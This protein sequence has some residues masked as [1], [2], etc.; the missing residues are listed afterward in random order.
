MTSVARVKPGSAVRESRCL[1]AVADR[2][3]AVAAV[4][5]KSPKGWEAVVGAKVFDEQRGL[6]QA[7]PDDR[8]RVWG[9]NTFARL[10]AI[11]GKVS[12]AAAEQSGYRIPSP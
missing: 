7:Q 6:A 9:V 8:G 12:D 10:P 11:G 3:E 4:R 1:E 5:E 2:L